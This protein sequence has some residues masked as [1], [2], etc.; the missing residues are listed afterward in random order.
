MNPS[1]P[2]RAAAPSADFTIRHAAPADAATLTAL[3]AS[4]FRET[5]APH[6]APADL[7]AYL[8]DHYSQAHQLAQL[9]APASPILLAEA[10]A[11]G[12]AIGFA[13]LHSAPPPACVAQFGPAPAIELGSLYVAA[14]WHDRRVGAALFAAALALADAA[15]C[16]T[17]W[18]GV[19]PDNHRALRFYYA[20]GF[21]RVGTHPFAVGQ[22]VDEDLLL[23]R[24]VGPG[25]AAD[26]GGRK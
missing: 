1:I 12:A 22:Q 26:A 6:Y 9:T 20:R 18:L 8:A 17:L 21:V 25:T 24:A 16:Q 19:W 11:D 7:A 5:W 14:A 4:T 3:M 23:A 10:T 13:R 2:T 15:G